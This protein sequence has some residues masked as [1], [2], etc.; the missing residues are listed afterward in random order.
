MLEVLLGLVGVSPFETASEASVIR[1][2][3]QLK[4]LDVYQPL[5]L[6][7]LRSGHECFCSRNIWSWAVSNRIWASRSCSEGSWVPEILGIS[8]SPA[9]PLMSERPRCSWLL[10]RVF[11]ITCPS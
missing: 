1:V 8:L 4:R 11:R 6:R 3:V 7:Q 9:G 5:D 2:K 10:G